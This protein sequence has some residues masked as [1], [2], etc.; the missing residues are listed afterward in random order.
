MKSRIYVC[1]TFYHALIAIVKE[2]VM[3]EEEY[4]KATLIL[5]KMSNDFGKLDERVRASGLFEEVLMYDEKVDSSFPELEKYRKDSGNILLNM[6]KRIVFTKKFGKLLEAD[7][8]V[9]F[10]NYRDIYVFCDSDPIGF[11]LSY[12]KIYYHALEDGL[13]TLKHCDHARF[14]NRGHFKLKAWMAKHNFIFIQNGYGKYCLDMEVNDISACP[15]PLPN[16]IEVNRNDLYAKMTK[17]NQDLLVSL[18]IENADELKEEIKKA[19]K[20]QPKY[21]VLTE[22]LC[23]LEVR[24]QLFRDVVAEY[25]QGAVPIIKPHPRDVVNYKEL[26]PND[27][28]IEG[29][30]P[31]EILNYIDGISFEKVISVFTVPGAI[32]FSGDV[33]FLGPD[34][35]D[36]YEDPEIHRE[37]ELIK[38]EEV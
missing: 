8:P 10:K 23:E 36:R 28:V 12:K 13:D 16:Y 19:P 5:S 22:P 15:Y 38:K 32:K 18:F 35:L 27:I 1:H 11:Y 2:M 26:F 9:D 17:E 3:P 4:G 21:L 34:F 20:D 25:C 33:V 30:F 31:M 14:S 37:N 7:V 29:K 24:K 6:W